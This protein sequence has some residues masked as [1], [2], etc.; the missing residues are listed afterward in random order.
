VTGDL[1]ELYGHRELFRNFLVRDVRGRYKGSALGVV[2]S[3]LNP[4]LMMGVYTLAFS[5]V[6]RVEVPG[7]NYPVFFL[8]GFLPWTFLATSI[9]LG[10]TTLLANGSLIQ[11]VYFPR[12]VLPLSMTGANLVN[13]LLALLFLLP[14]AIV[15]QGADVAALLALV[16]VTAALILLVAAGAMLAAVLT[17]YFRDLE[18]LLGVGLTAWFF[19]TP[20][21]YDYSLIPERL[22]WIFSLNPMVPFVEAYRDALYRLDVPSATR[23]GVCTLIGVAA[24]AVAYAIFNRL[25]RNVA[26]EL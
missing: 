26:E 17:V 8:A 1:A 6:M 4:L 24:F 18:F 12:E 21:V 20:V 9:Q 10:S 22:R 5:V 2:W 23:I 15:S 25:E 16:P 7:G 19:L 3:L 11:K 13:M 14:F